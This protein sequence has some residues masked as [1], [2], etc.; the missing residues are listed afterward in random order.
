MKHEII[1]IDIRQLSEKA[2]FIWAFYLFFYL[3]SLDFSFDIYL[4]AAFIFALISLSFVLPSFDQF[5]SSIFL[6]RDANRIDQD[7]KASDADRRVG[8]NEQAQHDR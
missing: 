1:A 5:L 2:G 3:F 7:G 4:I 8:P 6:H